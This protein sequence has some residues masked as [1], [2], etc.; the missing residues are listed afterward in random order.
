MVPKAIDVQ[1]DVRMLS[2]FK[3]SM[4]RSRVKSMA[5]IGDSTCVN[6][7]EEHTRL[8]I[9]KFI[10]KKSTNKMVGKGLRISTQASK[11]KKSSGESKSKDKKQ[12][13]LTYG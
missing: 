5:V 11:L 6:H 2:E 13:R 10:V 9:H 3:G 12:L 7:E 8:S 1:S 4:T